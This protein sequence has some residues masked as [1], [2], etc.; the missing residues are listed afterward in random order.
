MVR[1]FVLD[2]FSGPLLVNNISESLFLS[3][4]IHFNDDLLLADLVEK[5]IFHCC[6]LFP[7]CI[8]ICNPALF[9]IFYKMS[10]LDFGFLRTD[11]YSF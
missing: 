9:P 3:V 4:L 5:I 1:W 8:E 10:Y 6:T 11:S 7:D 2:F